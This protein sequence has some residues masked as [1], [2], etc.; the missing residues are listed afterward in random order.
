MEYISDRDVW[1]QCPRDY[2]W[3]Y[4]KLIIA[5]KQDVLS[6]PAGIPVPKSDWYI[7][8]PITNIRSM[9]RGANK[10]FLEKGDEE[11]VPDGFFW[12]EVIEGRHIS[13]DYHWGQQHLAV[14][15]FRDDPDILGR[16]S[17]WIKVSD[18]FPM[19]RILGDLWQ[20]T[21][22]INV[23]YIGKIAIE[24]HLRYNDDF[25]NHDSD[26]IIP[27]WRGDEVKQ[28]MGWSWYPNASGERLGFW[29]KNK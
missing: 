8:R 1:H 23:E 22:W 20:L 3:V 13:V 10:V 18:R 15:G 19:P 14:E 12:S 29:T 25:A 5:Q 2:L 28:P 4:D 17:R 9:G 11:S 6:A 27:V 16:F 26:E 21:A 24:V 7:V